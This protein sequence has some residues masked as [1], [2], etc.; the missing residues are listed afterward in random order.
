MWG[1]IQEEGSKKN[2]MK[3]E[4]VKLSCKKMEGGLQVLW[5]LKE[6][7][8]ESLCLLYFLLLQKAKQYYDFGEDEEFQCYTGF[9]LDGFQYI[10]CLPDGTWSQPSGRCISESFQWS[11]TSVHLTFSFCLCPQKQLSVK[12]NL[13]LY[14]MSALA[15]N[16]FSC[17]FRETVPSSWNPWW[18]DTLSK[19]R[20]VQSRRISGFEL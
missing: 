14:T 18:H 17:T 20:R 15:W 11:K 4:R 16:L 19:Q 8:Q 3:K 5:T 13:C 7:S 10:N 12:L 6:Y 1:V 9:D 2:K